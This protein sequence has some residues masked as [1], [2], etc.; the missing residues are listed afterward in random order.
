MANNP[1]VQTQPPS[2][3][4]IP[5]IESQ[6]P[7]LSKTLANNSICCQYV[8]DPQFVKVQ[9]DFSGKNVLALVDTGAGTSVAN[10]KF[11]EKI[12]SHVTLDKSEYDYMTTVNGGQMS[13]LGVVQ[14]VCTIAGCKVSLRVQIIPGSLYELVLGRDFLQEQGAIID[15]KQNTFILQS[16]SQDVKAVCS[17]EIPPKSESIIFG[18]VKNPL[19]S[20]IGFCQGHRVSQKLGLCVARSIV[21]PG[22]GQIPIRL[23]NPSNQSISVYK[24]TKVGT[25]H[26]VQECVEPDLTNLRA[27]ADH[28]SSEGL[29][30]PIVSS[31]LTEAEF[32]IDNGDLTGV[33]RK[34]L[35]DLLQKYRQVFASHPSELGHTKVVQHHIDVEAGQRPI[36]LRPYRAGPHQRA[37]IDENIQTLL[38]QEVIEPSNSPWAAPVVLVLKKDKTYRFCVDYRRL[39]SVTKF[40]SFPLSRIDD[41]FDTL[42]TTQ[43]YYFSTLDLMSGFFQVDLDEESRDKT[44]FVTHRGTYRFKRMPQGLVGAPATFS[45]L[46]ETVFRGLNWK[47][48]LA[49]LD[50]IIV[51]SHSFNDHIKH[52]TQVFD[53]LVSSNLKL[54]MNKCHFGKKQVQYLGHILSAQGISPD[55]QKV[56]AVASFPVPQ[57]AKAIRSFLGLTGFYRRFVNKYTVIAKPLRDLLRKGTKFVW[58]DEHEQAFKKLKEALI[59]S[60]LLAFPE[61]NTPFKL[62][63]DGSYSGIGAILTQSQNG[64]ER[65]VAYT[66]R[67]LNVHETNY[68]ITEI[69]ALSM[70]HAVS[71]FDVYLRH[72]PFTVYSDHSALRPLFQTK[73]ATGRLGRWILFMQGYKYEILYRPGQNMGHADALSRRDY[74][75]NTDSLELEPYIGLDMYNNVAVSTPSQVQNISPNLVKTSVLATDIQTCDSTEIPDWDELVTL[76]EVDHDCRPII[77]YLRDKILPENDIEARHLL[78][79]IDQYTLYDS[80]LYHIRNPRGKEPH[81]Q[82]VVPASLRKTVLTQTHSDVLGGHF[83]QDRTYALIQ[84]RYYWPGM[85]TDVSTF[86]SQCISCNQK[87]RPCSKIKAPLQP[88]PIPSSPFERISVDVVGPLPVTHSGKKYL[89]CFTDH[90]TRYPE[91][92]AVSDIK[93]STVARIF[94]DE[95]VCR[96]GAPRELLS[97][98][99]TNFLS[100][101][102][103]ETCKLFGTQQKFTSPYRPQTN[104]LQ[105]RY[106]AT[107]IQSLAMYVDSH[108]RDW[109]VFLPSVLFAFR[110]SPATRSTGHSPFM[111]LYGREPTLPLDVKYTMPMECPATVRD[112]LSMLI[113]KLET[114]RGIAITNLTEH[115]NQMKSQYDKTAR[116]ET[117]EV[118]DVVFVYCPHVKAHAS[119]KLSML[120]KGPYFIAQK[121]SQVLYKVRRLSDN[122]LLSVPVHVNRFKRA[123]FSKQRPDDLDPPLVESGQDIFAP[124]L[125]ENDLADNFSHSVLPPNLTSTLDQDIANDQEHTKN[126]K[127][128]STH[129]NVPQDN[130][131]LFEVEKIIKGRYKNGRLEYLVKWKGFPTAA[132]T[133]EPSTNLNQVTLDYLK[134]NPVKITGKANCSLFKCFRY[135]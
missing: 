113:T 46:V 57:N 50:D 121:V 29:V 15:F 112:H 3:V 74:P 87:K 133:W 56:E 26:P 52:L 21:D 75:R 107:L 102:V 120:W 20:I 49:Y 67:A 8:S 53:R 18:K 105:E 126:V 27:G 4:A 129:Q 17:F 94:F 135:F 23:L 122:K 104:G 12:P 24:N 95:I 60:P 134:E 108:H 114:V 58:L 115:K 5:D 81:R 83:G 118:G 47:I 88:L 77:R 91:V 93:A 38:D 72:A 33:Q 22:R 63:T 98:R 16:G 132:N 127:P 37:V 117:F 45:R 130:D 43:P 39:N 25:F 41:C 2:N 97:D 82:V 48:C 36:R 9:V 86:V 14:V 71:Q 101:L 54:K 68:P 109:D 32:N 11:L 6:G 73:D 44:T 110:A 85:Y 69:E 123:D 70:I 90:L 78:L 89:L 64:L 61:F 40:D 10:P 106:H 96:H 76:Q 84:L 99:G 92:F 28:M 30:S 51:F 19:N 66:G 59:N 128:T 103:K 79:K 80:I 13:V 119:K 31:V 42:G 116:L 1:V 55:P 34:T 111:L 131:E 124:E 65:V 62:Y 7:K 35:S 100:N 125:V